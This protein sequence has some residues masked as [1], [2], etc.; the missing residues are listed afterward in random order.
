MRTLLLLI[1]LAGFGISPALAAEITPEERKQI[2]SRM[3]SKSEYF[4]AISRKIWEFAEVGYKEAQ[5]SALLRDELQKNG[6]T[7][8]GNI[9]EIPT[10]FVA[11][12]GSGKPVIA[13]LGEFDALPGLSQDTSP[14]RKP[15]KG[16][17][18]GHGCGHNLFGTG[19]ALAAIEAKTYLETHKLPGTIRFYGTPAE[20]G[21]GG[22]IHMARAGAFAGVDVALHWHP[23]TANRVSVGGAL[24]NIN[25]K[26]RFH[27]KASH[28]AGAPEKGRSALDALLLMAHAVDML[29]EHVPQETRIH[30]IFT[31]GGA[32]PNVVPDFA[33]GYFYARHP[34]MGALDGIWERVVK[35][36]QA[37][38]L[39]TE[40]RMEMEIV[41]AVYNILPNEAL[42]SVVDRQLQLVG[43]VRYT[44]EEQKFAEALAK[45][46]PPDFSLP[47]GS[48]EQVQPMMGARG[49]G[50]STDVGDIS[51]IV[52][53]AGLGAATAVPGTPG[54]S[55]QNVACSGSSIGRKG[56]MVAA[57]TLALAAI[58]LVQNPKAVQ[59]AKT[60]FER[61]K[62]SR[63]YQSRVP[64]GQKAPL[65]YRDNGRS[66][67]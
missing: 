5:S 21:G 1:G 28:A 46:F 39:A 9:G 11:S 30:Y 54:H 41:N 60:D 2:L 17:A 42:S 53:T 26:F 61:A 66:I 18:P 33:E 55:W 10:A 7:I 3:D 16:G 12:W 50:G 29:R 44:A 31:N 52:P 4:G 48:Q 67:E 47:I 13:I 8:Q 49:S 56:M 43:G 34:D 14:E 15:I 25:A 23:G 64:A 51:W 19:S 45:T 35:C 62:G 59:D 38:A 24:A 40:T 20:E 6:F 37:G 22:K 27:G 65:N 63:S 58:E 57:K 32:A 36:A